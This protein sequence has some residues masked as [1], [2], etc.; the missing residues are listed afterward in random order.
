MVRYKASQKEETR[1]RILEAAGRC[2]R[3]GGYS[4]IGVDGLAKEAGVTSGAFYGH[5]GSK[6]EA[7]SAAIASGMAGVKTAIANLQQQ[8]GNHWWKEFA[9]FYMNQR[10]TCDLAESCVLQSL[11]PEVARSD[12][13]IRTLFQ[14]ELIK[15]AELASGGKAQEALDKTWVSLAM[16]TGGVTLARAVADEALAKEIATAI[17]NAVIAIQTRE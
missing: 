15:I 11:T 6:L 7:F 13:A 12:E 9:T 2:F 3:K 14:T 5:F 10:R 4:G 1:E 17:Q 8:Y 16:L